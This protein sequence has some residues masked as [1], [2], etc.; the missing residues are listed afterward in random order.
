MACND[1]LRIIKTLYYS[2]TTD[3]FIKE[4]FCDSLL[5]KTG[6]LK[7]NLSDSVFKPF[8]S[9]TVVNIT[10]PKFYIN[11]LRIIFVWFAQ[12]QGIL[13]LIYK[14]ICRDYNNEYLNFQSLSLLSDFEHDYFDE[15]DNGSVSELSMMSVLDYYFNIHMSYT[16]SNFYI[17]RRL[18]YWPSS[19]EGRGYWER[20]EDNFFT[21]LSNLTWKDLL[22]IL[23]KDKD[24][25]IRYM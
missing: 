11:L 20:C 10:M 1:I 12:R 6:L 25:I 23:V 17:I 18:F 14:N 21:F 19:D 22:I 8:N 5:E 3:S 4:T 16:E 15:L 24:M 7:Q 2:S 9:I 13:H